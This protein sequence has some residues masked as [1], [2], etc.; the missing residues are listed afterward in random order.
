MKKKNRECKEYL[1]KTFSKNFDKIFAFRK[2][3]YY[4]IDTR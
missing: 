2:M 1:E 3:L 4:N